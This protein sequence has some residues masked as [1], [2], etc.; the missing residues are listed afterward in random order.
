[1]AP[2]VLSGKYD[3]RC[4]LWSAGVMLYV[5]LCGY[6]PFYG[7]TEV[8]ILHMIQRGKFD[9]DGVEWTQVSLQARDLICR[10]LTIADQRL[11]MEEILKHEWVQRFK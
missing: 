2:E 5:L 6:P 4:D 9:F 7:E 10:L 8:E 3:N 1:M 11:G